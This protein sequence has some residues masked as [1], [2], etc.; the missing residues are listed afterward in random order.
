LLGDL[1]WSGVLGVCSGTRLGEV[2]FAHGQVVAATFGAEQGLPALQSIITLSN[3]EFTLERS[4][5]LSV[6]ALCAHAQELAKESARIAA[7][8]PS[9]AEVPHVSYFATQPNALE[10]VV[11]DHMALQVLLAVDGHNTVEDLARSFG[12]QLTLLALATLVHDRLVWFDQPALTPRS[13]GESALPEQIPC[14]GPDRHCKPHRFSSW[15]RV[16]AIAAEMAWLGIL[17][18]LPA[19]LLTLLIILT[20]GHR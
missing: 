20:S 14:A 13:L 2:A 10:E 5:D 6:T 9:V 7:A 18:Q 12:S 4:M 1:E 15:S 3:G 8:I 11:L 16:V 19:G 17:G